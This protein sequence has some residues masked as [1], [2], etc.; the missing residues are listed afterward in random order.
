MDGGGEK[1]IHPCLI[2][3]V[4]PQLVTAVWQGSYNFYCQDSHSAGE[5]DNKV[6]YSNW[7]S[8]ILVVIQFLPNFYCGLGLSLQI[9]NFRTKSL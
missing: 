6:S 8:L 2:H 1:E 7:T 4:C 9:I 5:A 3:L